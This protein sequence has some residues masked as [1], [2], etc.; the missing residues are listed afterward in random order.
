MEKYDKQ[1]QQYVDDFS[2]I[3]QLIPVVFSY[4]DEIEG[5]AQLSVHFFRTNPC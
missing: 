5:C 3:P 2:P 1:T 4:H